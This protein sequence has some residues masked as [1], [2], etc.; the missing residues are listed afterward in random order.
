[1]E[2]GVAGA[3]LAGL[4]SF[5][6]PC[7]LPLTP[8]YLSFLGGSDPRSI[9]QADGAARARLLGRAFAFVAGFA[10][11][12]VLLGAT[13]SLAGRFVAVWFDQ[14]AVLAGI[15]LIVLGLQIAGWLHIPFLM[16]ERRAHGP[17]AVTSPVGAYVVGLAFAFGWTPCVGPVLASILMLSGAQGSASQ[18][19]LLLCAYAAGLGLPFLLAAAF[20]PWFLKRSSRFS[21]FARPLSIIGGLILIVTGALITI[22]KFGVVGLWLLD[23]FPVFARFG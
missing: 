5:A 7:V 6:S 13:A 4:I 17:R 1:V 16:R 22:G 20:A 14:M 8:A 9:V 2:P 23:T 15:V 19:A 11:I 10:T 21:R 3:F 12:F 18:G